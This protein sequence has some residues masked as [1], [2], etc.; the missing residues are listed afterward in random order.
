MS[1]T[2]WPLQPEFCPLHA[3]I[4]IRPLITVVD[5]HIEG[6]R[7]LASFMLLLMSSC[8]IFYL[9]SLFNKCPQALFTAHGPGCTLEAGLLISSQACS[10][11]SLLRALPTLCSQVVYFYKVPVRWNIVPMKE[12]GNWGTKS[13]S[14]EE[15]TKRGCPRRDHQA[16]L[17]STPVA[18]DE[19]CCALGIAPTGC[20]HSQWPQY[21][22]MG[23][24][25]EVLVT[26]QLQPTSANL[27]K[28]DGFFSPKVQILLFHS[29]GC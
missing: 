1:E 28:T 29:M 7:R 5:D 16:L 15:A 26:I 22:A 21:G 17:F 3:H 6:L 8:S 23:V 14:S 19:G 10:P 18:A 12:K 27:L 2:R 13:L 24:A 4:G 11:C 25:E 20:G 9:T